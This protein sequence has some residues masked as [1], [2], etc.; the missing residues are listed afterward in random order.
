MIA[1]KEQIKRNKYWEE[2]VKKNPDT[3]QYD[4]QQEWDAHLEFI[5]EV[6]SEH[7]FAEQLGF[8]DAIKE[9]RKKH[10]ILFGDDVE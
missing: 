4:Y 8:V 3:E 10:K 1:S 7:M 6:D 2:Y 9:I 5:K